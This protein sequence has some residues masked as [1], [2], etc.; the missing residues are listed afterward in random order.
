M[1]VH[2][3]MILEYI[4]PGK[5]YIESHDFYIQNLDKMTRNKLFIAWN[6]YA[7]FFGTLWFA[8]RKMP[9]TGIILVSISGVFLYFTIELLSST[10]IENKTIL[11]TI[12]FSFEVLCMSIISIFSLYI[13]SI[14]IKIRYYLTN[15]NVNILKG[16]SIILLILMITFNLYLF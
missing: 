13:Y 8:Y 15:G 2:R 5:F 7:F 3:S 6:W 12:T 10:G 11:Y 14:H 9:L 16:K 1:E 4:H